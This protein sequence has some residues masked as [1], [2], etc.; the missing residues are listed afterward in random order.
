MSELNLFFSFL[1]PNPEDSVRN[2]HKKLWDCVAQDLLISDIL[3]T[4]IDSPTEEKE[5]FE[6]LKYFYPER[7]ILEYRQHILDDL[8]KYES[9]ERFFVALRD[10]A[11]EF[12]ALDKNEVFEKYPHMQQVK[13]F[14]LTECFLELYMQLIDGVKELDSEY[15]SREMTEVFA[16]I[17]DPERVSLIEKAY[18]EV[19]SIRSELNAVSRVRINRLFSRGENIENSITTAVTGSDLMKNLA[20][21]ADR[22]EID[23]LV[24][25][26]INDNLFP[27]TEKIFSCYMKAYPEVF[28]HVSE[29]SEKYYD[30]FN[31]DWFVLVH[32]T[33]TLLGLRML[34]KGLIRRGLPVCPVKFIERDKPVIIHNMYSL[35]LV[36]K[37]LSKS[38]IV[39]SDFSCNPDTH[40][41]LLTGPNGGGKTIF[42][43]ALGICQMLVQISGYTMASLAE[44]YP[45]AA[46]YTH[47][48]VEERNDSQ[49]RLVEEQSRCEKMLAEMP[50]GSMVLLNETYSSTKADVAY[51]LST[52]LISD[53]VDKDSFGLFVTHFHTVK[54]FCKEY[55]QTH[56]R[57]ICLLV[58]AVDESV[59]ERRLYKIVPLESANSSYSRDILLRHRMTREQLFERC[60][61][62]EV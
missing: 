7:E 54:E 43:T 47:F 17:T 4:V 41:N 16:A 55:S 19:K 49:G 58:A 40:F 12:A 45:V 62:K 39:C 42:L 59:D 15:L 9:V 51:E 38:E 29:F 37:G 33:N 61:L 56:E 3:R 1:F 48:P 26:P 23:P 14:L 27:P 2:G 10:K 36:N 52:K 18:S 5:L 35:V 28:G 31:A 57:K 25:E 44:M 6:E 50:E 30:M 22:M 21:L 34:Y 46:L 8:M 20:S 53:L 24:Q 32:E 60:H 11:T 13:G